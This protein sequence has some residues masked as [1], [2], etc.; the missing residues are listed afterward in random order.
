MIFKKELSSVVVAII[1]VILISALLITNVIRLSDISYAVAYV[2]IAGII[3]VLLWGFKAKINYQIK[4]E[5]NANRFQHTEESAKLKVEKNSKTIS[6]KTIKIR[7]DNYHELK[8]S[9]KKGQVIRGKVSSDG[10]FNIYFLTES[11]FRSFK[12]DYSFQDLD[13]DDEVS[14]FTF[15]FEVPSKGIYHIV[16]QNADRKNIVVTV[17]LYSE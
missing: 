16:F 14:N 6:Q 12:N 7:L 9:L 4:N 11:S 2:I 5:E 17:N 15:D 8:L 13:G 1:L 10:C 3:G